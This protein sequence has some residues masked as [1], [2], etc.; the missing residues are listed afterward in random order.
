MLERVTGAAAA[1]RYGLSTRL[2]RGA[3]LR[4]IEAEHGKTFKTVSAYYSVVQK[5]GAIFLK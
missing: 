5:S 4:L 3:A 2:Q 1:E